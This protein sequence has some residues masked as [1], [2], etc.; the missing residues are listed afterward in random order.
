VSKTEDYA[1]VKD[2]F[3]EIALLDEAGWNHNNCY[4]KHLLKFV[5]EGAGTALDIGCGK[6]ELS[7]LLSRKCRRVIAVDLAERMI[8]RAKALHPG[9]NID[10]LCANVLDMKFDDNSL[11]VI[12]TTATAHHLP[13]E[14]LL[15]FARGKLKRG[16]VLII[17]DLAKA[18]TV[19]DYIVWGGAFFPNLIMNLL[20]NGRLQKDDAH[21]RAVWE[22]HGQH[23]TYMTLGEVRATAR[24]HLPSAKV[25]RKLFWRYTLVWRK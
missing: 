23:D 20:K 11:D 13:Y 15:D 18:K 5:P 1:V 4:I 24:R 6:G 8:E 21:A 12:I 19:T 10:Y 2:D 25:K 9:D 3:N 14:W 7:Y 16:G 17:L 22:S